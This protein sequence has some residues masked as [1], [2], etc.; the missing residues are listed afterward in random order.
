MKQWTLLD[1]EVWNHF[2]K[3][4]G[5]VLELRGLGF[6]KYAAAWDYE[7]ATGT[8]AGYFNDY[9]CFVHF[10]K[11]LMK[12]DEQVKSKGIYFTLQV[13]NPDL[14]ARA[15]NRILPAKETTSDHDVLAYRWLPIDLDPIRPAGISSSDEELEHA[16]VLSEK[17]LDF[18][19]GR[20][21]PKPIQ[22]MSGN[23]YHL[24]YPLADFP[25][26][27]PE[28]KKY[29][30]AQLSELSDKFSNEHVKVD[31][32]LF[33]PARI[34]KLYGT[35]A[36]KGDPVEPSPHHVGRPHRQSYIFNLGE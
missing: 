19:E 20:G 32:A 31:K 16:C 34:I 15:L 8:V 29:V 28:V 21:W 18:N 5:E 7:Y 13:I 30:K 26:Q 25:A 12:V 22:A 9:D 23:G 33:N 36:R 6:R 2:I 11:M 27:D 14:I 10:T 24:L 17:I 4:A 3:K 35:T 1:K